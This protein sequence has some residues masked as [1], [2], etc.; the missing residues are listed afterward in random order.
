MAKRF[1][2]TSKWTDS[3]FR[4][5]PPRLK[6][7]WSYMCDICDHAGVLSLDIE[8]MSF[9]VGEPISIDEIKSNF[10][11]QVHFINDEK[12]IITEF[13]NFQYGKL[14]PE[15]RVHLSV[16]NRLE[17]L[18]ATKGL[19]STL[20]GAKDKDKDKDKDLDE[21]KDKESISKKIE[22][23][24]KEIYPLKKGKLK[25]VEK[26][27]KEIK[28]DEDLENLK[29]AISR[30]SNSVSGND[31]KYIKHF[32]TFANTWKECLEADYGKASTAISKQASSA[33]SVMDHN[34]SQAARV[35]AG[36]L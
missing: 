22:K 1:T 25:G 14:N 6:A 29:T 12:I 31:P 34:K 35:L 30:Y 7:A 8:T 28:S 15:N 17:K 11:K 10:K 16:L 32:S 36:E 23:L 3:W 4:K 2:E 27:S 20:N 9:L 33:Q 21:D 26:L 24:Y 19:I 5:L 13:I 18:G